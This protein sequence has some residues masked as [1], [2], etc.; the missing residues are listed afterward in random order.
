MTQKQTQKWP[1]DAASL[2]RSCGP[3]FPADSY[4]VKALTGS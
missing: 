3:K 1:Y 4:S 2:L